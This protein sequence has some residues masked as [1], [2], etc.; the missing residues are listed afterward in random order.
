MIIKLSALEKTSG[1]KTVTF[2]RPPAKNSVMINFNLR[3][4]VRYRQE[5]EQSYFKK[6]LTLLR[7]TLPA[8]NPEQEFFGPGNTHKS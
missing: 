1:K 5:I 2:Q 3:K 6:E 4:N 8:T 7:G